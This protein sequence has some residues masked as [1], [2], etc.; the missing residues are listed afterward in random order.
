MKGVRTCALVQGNPR[1]GTQQ[2]LEFL[3]EKFDCVIFSTWEGEDLGS[4]SLDRVQVV[5]SVKPVHPGVTHR[6]YQRRSTAAG[7]LRARSLG[8]TH[9]LKWRT[10]M[11]PTLL[12]V[13]QLLRW[14]AFELPTGF[15][16]RLVTCAFRNLSVEPDWF[17]SV[18]DLFG[19]ADIDRMFDLWGDE[20]FDYAAP[21]NVPAAMLTDCGDEWLERADAG[22]LYCAE[23]ELYALFKSRLQTRV[24]AELTHPRIAFE[25]MRLI[26]HK[27]L[28]ICWFD[29]QGGFRCISQALQHPWWTEDTWKSGHPTAVAWGYPEKGLLAKWRRKYL[30]PRVIRAELE[31]QVRWFRDYL[32]RSHSS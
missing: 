20:S 14:S 4:L 9:V 28:G 31:L 10:D 25:H 18:P 5:L 3:V 27:R 16:S 6:N 11:L 29:Q 1:Y 17:S 22:G 15:Q 19:F 24:G 21:M 23:S 12:D 2:V 30:S 13:E 26:D 7:L 32:T 8:A